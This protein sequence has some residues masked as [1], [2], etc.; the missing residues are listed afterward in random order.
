MANQQKKKKS[1]KEKAS[2]KEKREQKGGVWV[3]LDRKSEGAVGG[4]WVRAQG[5]ERAVLGAQGWGLS[6]AG[7]WPRGAAGSLRNLVC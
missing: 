2:M 1:K 5:W 3:K 7:A 4:R 6:G